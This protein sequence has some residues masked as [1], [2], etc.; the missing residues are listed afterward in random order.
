M[1]TGNQGLFLWT[2]S[3]HYL[4]TDLYVIYLATWRVFPQI[5][6]LVLL[7]LLVC[8]FVQ[9]C[10]PFGQFHSVTECQYALMWQKP[11][12]FIPTACN[13]ISI[14]DLSSEFKRTH[15]R[16]LVLRLGW[17]GFTPREKGKCILRTL[18]C[19]WETIHCH[20]SVVWQGRIICEKKSKLKWHVQNRMVVG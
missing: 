17:A 20:R 13:I 12:L 16:A 4:R 19:V 8:Y 5:S 6:S 15:N 10:F 7:L 1:Q 11:G 3:S 2:G 18:N 9:V 14:L